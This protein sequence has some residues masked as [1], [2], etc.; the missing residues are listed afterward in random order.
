MIIACSFTGALTGSAVGTTTTIGGIMIP[1]MRKY[2]YDNKYLVALLSY[3][4]ILGT[5]I[6][7]SISGLI[8]AVVVRLPV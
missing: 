7:P 2:N 6:P 3:S 5:L 1:Q 8:F 4:G